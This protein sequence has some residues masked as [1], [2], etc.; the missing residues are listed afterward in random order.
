MR[1][2]YDFQSRKAEKGRSGRALDV[3]QLLIRSGFR[4]AWLEQGARNED[5]FI[6]Q[7]TQHF[8]DVDVQFWNDFVLSYVN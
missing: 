2:V 1:H 5:L 4:E 8:K 6:Q 7:F 3:I